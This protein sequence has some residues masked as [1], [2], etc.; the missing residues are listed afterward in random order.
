MKCP[1]VSIIIPTYNRAHLI[2]ETLDSIIAQTDTNWECIVVDDGST[3]H[4]DELLKKYCKR[5]NRFQYYHRPIN[6]PK[7]ANACRNYGLEKAKGDY[8]IFFDSD[9]LMLTEHIEIKISNIVLYQ[10]DYIITKTKYLNYSE[11]NLLL[12]N[13]YNFDSNKITAYN[14]ISQKINW[15]TLDVCINSRIAKSI[16]F[17]EQLQSGQEYNYFSKLTLISKEA[18]FIDE[19]VSLRRFHENSIRGNLRKDRIIN[20][21][22]FFKTYWYTYQDIKIEANKKI[23][24]YLVYKCVMLA[25]K[26]P[27]VYNEFRVKLFKAILKEYGIKGIYHIVK[28]NFNRSKFIC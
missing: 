21:Q 15:L 19:T 2:G 27:M 9:D 26:S 17:N 11:G 28:L 6:R 8:I 20:Y 16:K 7:G 14:Y 18:Q 25:Y 12:E 24:K 3:D 5:D 1:L 22:G 13:N 23:K 4:T 10:R